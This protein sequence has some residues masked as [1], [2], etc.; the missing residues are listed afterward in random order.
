MKSPALDVESKSKAPL[1]ELLRWFFRRYATVIGLILL[2]IL[3]GALKPKIFLTPINA[4]NILISVA[5]LG[6]LA[7]GQTVVFA[8]ND[9]DM[10]IGSTASMVGII[11]GALMANHHMA[12]PLAVVVGI[13]I[14]CVAGAFN[15]FMV[16]Y[17]NLMPFLATMGTLTAYKGIAYLW[18]DGATVSGFSNGFLRI[19]QARIGSI[20]YL[21]IILVVV[22]IIAY[23][24][25]ERTT[26][27]RRWYALG[28]NYDAS[29]LAGIRVRRLRMLAFVISGACAALAGIMLM[30]RLSSATPIM[31]DP[32]TLNAVAGVF[33]GMTAFKEGVPNIAGSIVGVLM[34]GVLL[35]GLTDIGASIYVQ[36]MATGI[37]IIASVVVAGLSKKQRA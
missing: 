33:L 1:G 10:S 23:F 11:I 37:V 20:P 35:N 9:F 16:A 24:V 14:G 4:R 29:Y 28:G 7:I 12:W 13:L 26:V 6:V 17:V 3:F 19:G 31:G 21:I 2:I 30:S 27:G 36:M 25:M 8:L 32:L 15:G 18:Q 34:L 22:S 5:V